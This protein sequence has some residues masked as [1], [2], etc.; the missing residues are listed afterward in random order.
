MAASVVKALSSPLNPFPSAVD[1]VVDVDNLRQG[2][3]PLNPNEHLP[4]PHGPQAIDEIV[5]A[6]QVVWTSPFF[7]EIRPIASSMLPS[8]NHRNLAAR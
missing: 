6:R 4:P 5:Q 1:A 2:T 7:A 8:S 3:I